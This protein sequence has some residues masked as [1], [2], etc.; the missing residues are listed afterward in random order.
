M[1]CFPIGHV[2]H[3]PLPVDEKLG[4]IAP[5]A[6][7]GLPTRV[8]RHGTKERDAIEALALQQDLGVRRA[9][10]N[11]VF[12]REPLPWLQGGMDGG[13]QVI[14]GWRGGGGLDIDHSRWGRWIT[15]FRAMH[16]RAEPLHR[17]SC[18][19]TLRSIG[20]ARKPAPRPLSAH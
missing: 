4:V 7:P 10:L 13:H 2:T 16:L 17:G 12:R 11:Q 15:G 14:I 5:G 20:A 1:L 19:P 3:L 6:C 8:V 9:L 18:T